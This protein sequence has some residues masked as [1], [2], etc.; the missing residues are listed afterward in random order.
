MG[1]NPHPSALRCSTSRVHAAMCSSS[2]RGKDEKSG[3]VT[4]SHGLGRQKKKSYGCMVWAPRK[5]KAMGAWVDAPRPLS[6]GSSE[7]DLRCPLHY[8]P[9]CSQQVDRE[10]TLEKNNKIGVATDFTSFWCR[11]RLPMQLHLIV[12]MNGIRWSSF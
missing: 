11:W 12:G 7:V 4:G 2:S 3:V 5:H 9:T 10:N 6:L 8:S 1:P